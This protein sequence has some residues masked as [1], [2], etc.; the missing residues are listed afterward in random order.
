MSRANG[1]NFARL[2]TY[3]MG[4]ILLTLGVMMTYFSM[5]ADKGI[6]TPRL[7]TLITLVVA[8][9]GLI[10]FVVRGE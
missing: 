6:I 2:T 7:Y 3:F 5:R 10:M 8:F 4:A 9:I 1:L